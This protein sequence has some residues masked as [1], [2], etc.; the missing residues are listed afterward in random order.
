VT[1]FTAAVA[2]LGSQVRDLST[3]DW[4]VQKQVVRG[5]RNGIELLWHGVTTAEET[6][7]LLQPIAICCAC[8][9]KMNSVL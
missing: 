9:S 4:H 5:T 6:Q 3:L 1:V 7:S 8:V 2:L